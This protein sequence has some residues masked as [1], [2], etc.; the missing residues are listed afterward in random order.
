MLGHM[1][2]HF[3]DKES[4]RARRL[5]MRHIAPLKRADEIVAIAFRRVVY[6]SLSRFMN[7]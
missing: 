4:Q 5:F 6:L 2:H 1:R 7:V 3:R